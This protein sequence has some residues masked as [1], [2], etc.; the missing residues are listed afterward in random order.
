MN[1]TG[2]EGY[3]PHGPLPTDEDG[4]GDWFSMPKSRGPGGG[5]SGF[6]PTTSVRFVHEHGGLESR[7][8]DNGLRPGLSKHPAYTSAPWAITPAKYLMKNGTSAGSNYTD[9]AQNFR[10]RLASQH[11]SARLALQLKQ[12]QRER[13]HAWREHTNRINARFHA[14][15]MRARAMRTGAS[16][17]RAAEL[18]AQVDHVEGRLNESLA[19]LAE[20]EAEL[21][22]RNGVAA[23]PP[24][25][26]GA[27]SPRVHPLSNRAPT[28]QPSYRKAPMFDGVGRGSAPGAATPG[29]ATP[30][31]MAG[32][33]TFSPRPPSSSSSRSSSARGAVHLK[34]AA[35][36]RA[37][38]L[39]ARPAVSH[40][41]ATATPQLMQRGEEPREFTSFPQSPPDEIQA[42]ELS[43]ELM[44]LDHTWPV[45]R[46]PNF[47]K[48]ESA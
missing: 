6:S 25:R 9:R 11:N 1:F 7:L 32:G 5:G 34:P 45:E 29:A 47:V 23:T 30:A 19:R 43:D 2:K 48:D 17:R 40:A 14:S 15:T 27:L 3:I 22:T 36:P 31:S 8:L 20:A 18:Q 10:S 41:P 44:L 39:S 16:P 33:L 4:D 13:E 28:A 42:G 24:A 26:G 46:M 35:S 12:A 21:A 38:P 37:R